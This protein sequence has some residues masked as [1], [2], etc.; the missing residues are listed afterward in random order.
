MAKRQNNGHPKR[1]HRWMAAGLAGSLGLNVILAGYLYLFVPNSPFR[2]VCWH[3]PGGGTAELRGTIAWQ[4]RPYLSTGLSEYGIRVGPDGD[5]LYVARWER[6]FDNEMLWNN[7]N[8]A[9]RAYYEDQGITLDDVTCK[10]VHAA[11][12]SEAE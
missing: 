12:I 6:W 5:S 4:F 3:M 2:P 9:T 7:T 10:E 11:A 1:R 8:K